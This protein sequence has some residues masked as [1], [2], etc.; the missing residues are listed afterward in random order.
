[1]R[2]TT[3]EK[4]K[5]RT[6]NEDYLKQILLILWAL[7]GLTACNMDDDKAVYFI[8]DQ[9]LDNMDLDAAF[10]TTHVVDLA[11][12]GMHLDGLI[13]NPIHVPGDAVAVV[14]LGI[15]DFNRK[16]PSNCTMQEY[17]DKYE[18]MLSSLGAERVVVVSQL[19]TTISERN[20][21]IMLFNRLLNKRLANHPDLSLLDIYYRF[22]DDNDCLDDQF[23][24]FDGILLND[25]GYQILGEEIKKA[26]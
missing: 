21:Y 20:E 1:L 7:L 17:V 4:R 18:Q 14:F 2:R 23:A 10:P 24:R 25:Y 5:L 6:K 12:G 11:K 8:G 19:P 9:M 3:Y 16:G 22:A 15:H 26:L 13:E